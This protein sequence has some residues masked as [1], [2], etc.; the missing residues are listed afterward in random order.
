MWVIS[1]ALGSVLMI[2]HVNASLLI[3][4]IAMVLLLLLVYSFTKKLKIL[5]FHIRPANENEED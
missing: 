1:A 5:F 4:P 2:W 3:C